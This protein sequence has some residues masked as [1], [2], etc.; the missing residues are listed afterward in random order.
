MTAF[1]MVYD[2]SIVVVFKAGAHSKPTPWELKVARLLGF[3]RFAVWLSD[4]MSAERWQFVE[5]HWQPVEQ[6]RKTS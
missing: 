4:C 1:S 5:G 6:W 3:T 2:G